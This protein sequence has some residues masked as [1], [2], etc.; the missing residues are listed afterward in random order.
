MPWQWFFD[1]RHLE[2]LQLGVPYPQ[3]VAHVRQLLAT[4]PLQRAT[5]VV[6]KTGVGVAVGQL[7]LQAGARCE[8]VTI[9]AGHEP[10]EP[11]PGEHRVPKGVLVSRVQ[12]LLHQQRLRIAAGLPN[13]PLLVEEL[14]SFEVGFTST[15][16][17]TFN[18]RSGKHDD[19]VLAT[20]L[21][22]WYAAE[23]L[24][25]GSPMRRLRI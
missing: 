9:T 10:T 16:H 13:A 25:S 24:R 2:R 6:D 21:A 15:G 17:M 18:A 19:L 23:K 14:K 11:H 8:L 5:L 3:Q 1:V 12:S 22:V 20:S 4:P 7:F